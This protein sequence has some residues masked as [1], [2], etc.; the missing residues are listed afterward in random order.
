M[1]TTSALN[2]ELGMEEK[3]SDWLFNFGADTEIIEKAERLERE[4]ERYRAALE[5]NAKPIGES[6]LDHRVQVAREAL[7]IA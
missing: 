2:G 4:H 1:A 6:T 7:G 3:V 5:E